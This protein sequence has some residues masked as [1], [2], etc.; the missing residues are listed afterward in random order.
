M[1]RAVSTPIGLPSRCRWASTIA[2][3]STLKVARALI[4]LALV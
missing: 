3:R 1:C 4:A 2:I